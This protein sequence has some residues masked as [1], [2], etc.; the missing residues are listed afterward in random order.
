MQVTQLLISSIEIFDPCQAL[1]CPRVRVHV[2]IETSH[3]GQVVLAVVIGGTNGQPQTYTRT[4]SGA[5]AYSVT[6]PSGGQAPYPLSEACPNSPVRG[7]L[8]VATATTTP[9]APAPATASR[10]CQ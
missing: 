7:A 10:L 3:Q 9:A 6:V 1:S 2:Q 8:V 4:L 5:T